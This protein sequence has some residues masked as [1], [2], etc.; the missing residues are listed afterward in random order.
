VEVHSIL[1][2]LVELFGS[3]S[4]FHG[5]KGDTIFSFARTAL[6]S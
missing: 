5:S 4:D 6:Q 2:V 3:H 1:F